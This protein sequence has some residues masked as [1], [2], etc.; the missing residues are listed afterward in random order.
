[1]TWR[2][3]SGSGRR[4][5]EIVASFKRNDVRVRRRL[6]RKYWRRAEHRTDQMLHAATNFVVGIAAKNGAALALEDLTDIR[7]MYRQGQR[8]GSRL[9]FR[10]NSWPHWK[11]K[12]MLEYKAAWKGRDA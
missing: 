10:L 8:T 5:R 3:L 7:K 4:R 1:M 11:A 2:R 12:Q 9:S 6:A